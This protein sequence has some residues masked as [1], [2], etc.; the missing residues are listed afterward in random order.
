[1]RFV[2]WLIW[3][4]IA[5]ILIVFAVANRQTMTLDLWPFPFAFEWPVCFVV[6]L[7]LVVGFFIGEFV[8]WVNGRRWRREARR[9]RHRIEEL[10]RTLAARTP[11][12]EAPPTALPPQTSRA[13]AP[14]DPH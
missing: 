9:L 14:A 1:M 11:P 8:A 10:E 4:L 13:I 6:L 12:A 3:G 5:L 7:T 2:R